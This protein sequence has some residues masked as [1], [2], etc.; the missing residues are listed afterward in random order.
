VSSLG[1]TALYALIP[2][3]A[4]VIAGG[5]ALARPA[6]PKMRSAIMHLAGG[7]VFA[8]V[9]IELLPAIIHSTAIVAVV[10]GFSVGAALM[11]VL[12][13]VLEHDNEDGEDVGPPT[14]M[15]VAVGVDLVVDGLMLGL[16]FAAG[17]RAGVLLAI[18]LT[19]ETVSLGL[20]LSTKLR[21]GGATRG[22][23]ITILGV[24]GL[25]L[26]VGAV[27]GAVGLTVLPASLL[28]G[29]LA[30]GAAALLFLVTEELLEEAHEVKETPVLT[31]MFFAG[32]LALMVLE[33]AAGGS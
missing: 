2:I 28:P 10:I 32:F 11:L 19:L 6:G 30:F 8:V 16:G 5:V 21:D 13:Q 15:I 22:R 12:R 31:A 14:A 23:V 18:G 24:L 27:I 33:M 4:L 7:V 17:H 26:A 9:A 1:S 3:V 29:L 20:A 25:A